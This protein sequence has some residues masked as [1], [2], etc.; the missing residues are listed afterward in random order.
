MAL[1][2]L[3]LPPGV[4]RNGTNYEASGRFWD[5]SLV[6]FFEGTIRPVGGWRKL[7][8]AQT[9]L[10][11]KARAIHAWRSIVSKFLAIGTHSKLYAST[12]GGAFEDITPSGFTAGRADSYPG[13]GYGFGTYS[14]GNYNE[15]QTGTTTLDATTWSLDN[16]G[17][18]LVGCS[19]TDGKIY[20]W[21]GS[22]IATVVTNA[23]TSNRMI[24]VTPE[25]HLVAF[26]S[27]GDSRVVA[28]SSQEDRNL[29]TPA[30]TNTA[31][32]LQLQTQGRIIAAKKVRGQTLILTDQDAHLMTY[33]GLPYIYGIERV[34]SGCG[35]VGA[36][37]VAVV[38]SGAI[39]MGR[40]GFFTF[41]GSVQPLPS[42][43]SDYVFSDINATEYPKVFAGHNSLFR[44]VWFFYC[45]SG[46]T[47]VDRY[48]TYN[49]LENHWSIGSL[50]RTCWADAGVLTKPA[51]VSADG[52]VY[53]HE[54]GWTS[55]GAEIGADRYL[56][57]GPVEVATGSNILYVRQVVP[58]ERSA[59]DVRLRFTSKFTPE[60]DE[61]SFG[62]YTLSPYTDARL[63]GR[64]IAMK[65]E[66]VAD[67][68]WRVGT[69]RFE[70]TTGG[71]R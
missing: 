58:D 67:D 1:V 47:E 39:W 48:V 41:N 63:S 45:S 10:T 49:Y 22:G 52:Y 11:G 24:L 8:Q 43:V 36:N 66:G 64:Q 19:T 13:Q 42:D 31:G 7:D 68:D 33:R 29:W 44:E 35:C 14:E 32:D 12:D 61:Y 18:Y 60:G 59:G 34:G 46:S 27:G 30:S 4:H 65:I 3:K 26:G 38:D 53:E 25:R 40:N 15:S 23:P 6:R 54:S 62:P 51:A 17:D 16:W 9:A 21:S 70:G 5:A 28:W 55:D 71:Q 20:E 69:I 50:S 2:P 37:A 57:S 56:T